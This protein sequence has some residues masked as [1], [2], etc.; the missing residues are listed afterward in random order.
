MLNICIQIGALNDELICRG[1][2]QGTEKQADISPCF[3]K[4]NRSSILVNDC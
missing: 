2:E 1:R 3:Q 4:L